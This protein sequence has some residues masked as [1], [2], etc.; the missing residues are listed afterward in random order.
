VGEVEG[1][2]GRSRLFHSADYHRDSPEMQ[3]Q[4]SVPLALTLI[5]PLIRLFG[6]NCIFVFVHFPRYFDFI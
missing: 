4:R 5:S 1:S 3:L 6:R 2:A